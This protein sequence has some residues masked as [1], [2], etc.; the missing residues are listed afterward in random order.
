LDEILPLV[1]FHLKHNSIFDI[2]FIKVNIVIV[3]CYSR[4]FVLQ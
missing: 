3:E 1:K 2:I 4:K